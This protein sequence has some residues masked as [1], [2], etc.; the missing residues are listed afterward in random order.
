MVTVVALVTKLIWDI[1]PLLIYAAVGID[2]VL[3]VFGGYRWLGTL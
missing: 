1:E 2:A 3:F